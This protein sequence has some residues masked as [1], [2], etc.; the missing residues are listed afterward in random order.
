MSKR[1][2]F[3]F[4]ENGDRTA[5]QDV[6]QPSGII[7]YQDGYPAA[8]SLDIV[9]DPT[10]RRVN[11]DRFNQLMFDI[12]SNIKEWQEQ[13]FPDYIQP[14]SNGGVNYAYPKG[15]T[16][17]FNGGYR[18]SLVDGNDTQPDN[19]SNWADAFPLPVALGGTGVETIN[20]QKT[21]LGVAPQAT[22]QEA[23]DGA[24]V[25]AYMPPN[26][27]HESFNQY[28]IGGKPLTLVSNLD[29]IDLFNGSF[30]YGSGTTGAPSANVGVGKIDFYGFTGS[31]RVVVRV[32]EIEPFLLE[33]IGSYERV[34]NDGG[35]TW[36]GWRK[37]ITSNDK[38]TISDAQAGTDD[39][40]YVTPKG[41]NEA[42]DMV[43]FVMYRTVSTAPAGR[44]IKANGFE[45]SRTA[46]AELFAEASASVNFISQATKDSDPET[47][48]GYYGDGDG[49]TTFTL[50]DLRA[51]IIRGFDDGRGIDAGRTF[52]SFQGDAIRNIEGSINTDRAQIAGSTG[53]FD[54]PSYTA[55]ANIQGTSRSIGRGFSFDAS[56]VVPTASENR[57]RNLA[58]T[59]WV[60]Y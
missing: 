24:D 37:D 44:W 16:V 45:V 51:E 17:R 12:T 3:P 20:E 26:L 34:S 29:E 57:M 28:G 15:M 31:E 19:A 41:V 4:A 42:M 5:I 35:A 18:I 7:N 39:E 59:A 46:Y 25:D 36:S 40:Q 60:R 56:R 33:M 23:L 30:Y 49:S 8:Y 32:V 1:I 9:T 58:Y 48:A 55:F 50:P 11:R 43:G 27:V 13:S 47:Y 2:R 54:G 10:A 6:T 21:Q 22:Q 38:A 14:S 53:A 52:G